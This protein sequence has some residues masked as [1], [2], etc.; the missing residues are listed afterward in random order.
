[1]FEVLNNNPLA[2]NSILSKTV[3]QGEGKML[4]K[5]NKNWSNSLPED[6]LYKNYEKTCR[7]ETG[8]YRRQGS[9][10]EKE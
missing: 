8:I 5:K 2:L 4:S 7:S 1:M 6:L 3:L 10:A 9:T